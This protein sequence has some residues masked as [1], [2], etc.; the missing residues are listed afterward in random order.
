M[1]SR[2]WNKTIFLK[3]HWEINYPPWENKMFF[4]FCWCTL[5]LLC[6]WGHPL[7]E[8]INVSTVCAVSQTQKIWVTKEC[9][10]KVVRDSIG[11]VQQTAT[12][13]VVELTLAW[14][15]KYKLHCGI[16]PE[17]Y[18]LDWFSQPNRTV[19]T[20]KVLVKPNTKPQVSEQVCYWLWFDEYFCS[21][22]SAIKPAIGNI[23]E[24]QPAVASVTGIC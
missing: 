2:K 1:N 15:W 12:G 7:T 11:W 19:C 9:L 17:P 6:V 13:S 23:F 10:Q 8:A 3:D 16:N 20:V 22:N 18:I 5:C 14:F 24:R 21:A 4:F